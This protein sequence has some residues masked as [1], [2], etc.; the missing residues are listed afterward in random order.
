MDLLDPRETLEMLVL[1]EFPEPM[2]VMDLLGLMERREIWVPPVCPVSPELREPR[3]TLDPWD[4]LDPKVCFKS[5]FF[6]FYIL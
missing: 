4:L 1:M 6:D 2:V 3:E 5:F